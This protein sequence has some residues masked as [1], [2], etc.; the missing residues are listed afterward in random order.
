MGGHG[1]HTPSAVVSLSPVPG[2]GSCGVGRAVCAAGAPALAVGPGFE[3]LWGGLSTE[4]RQSGRQCISEM[5]LEGQSP[6]SLK[7]PKL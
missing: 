4:L 6:T 1:V 2:G 5:T 3:V 7:N